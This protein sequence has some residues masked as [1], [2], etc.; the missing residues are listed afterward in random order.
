MRIPFERLNATKNAFQINNGCSK[1]KLASKYGG[2]RHTSTTISNATFWFGVTFA[3]F[4]TQQA[5]AVKHETS[6]K[7]IR[8]N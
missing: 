6:M 1:I 5:E 4:K 2:L 7:C 3:N 8:M